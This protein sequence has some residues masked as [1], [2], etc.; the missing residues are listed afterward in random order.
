MLNY[1]PNYTTYRLIQAIDKSYKG[2]IIIT[3]TAFCLS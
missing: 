2:T 3:I 1:V